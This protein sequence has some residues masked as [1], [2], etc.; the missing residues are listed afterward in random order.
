MIGGIVVF[1]LDE[2]VVRDE[3]GQEVSPLDDDYDYYKHRQLSP[4]DDDW[5]KYDHE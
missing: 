2:D 5:C 3:N 4:L 1:E